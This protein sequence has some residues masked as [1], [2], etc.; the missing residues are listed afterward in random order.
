MG[1]LCD[2]IKV[3]EN[4][5]EGHKDNHK[6]NSDKKDKEGGTQK[7]RAERTARERGIK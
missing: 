7:K 6:D 2:V 4:H 1:L 3:N 5:E